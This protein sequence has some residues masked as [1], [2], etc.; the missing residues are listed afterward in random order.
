[1]LINSSVRG[2]FLP[3]HLRGKV[4]WTT[5]FIRCLGGAM[6]MQAPCELG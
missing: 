2:P 5:P 3:N 6:M 4:H 1:M